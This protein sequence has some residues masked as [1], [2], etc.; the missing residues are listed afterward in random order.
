MPAA[1]TPAANRLLAA[2]DSAA[3][4]R[5]LPKLETVALSINDVLYEPGDT[6]SDVYFPLDTIVSLSYVLED[7]A[8]T[9][10]AVVG[11]EGM[12]GLAL[13]TGGETAPFRAVVQSDG[14]A[15]RMKGKFLK[16]E[17]DRFERLHTLLL[18][19]IQSLLTQM[20]QNAV[21]NRHHTVD[22]QLCRWLLLSLDRV[23]SKTL[24]MTQELIAT[25]LGV[26]REAVTTAARA[27]QR[28]GVIDYSRGHITVLDRARLEASSC[29]CYAVVR[30]ETDRL[31]PP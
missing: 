11:N 16:A 23:P 20:A 19:Y 14:E 6:V 21:C 31:L 25:N 2:L 9:D 18:R 24:H 27:L 13:V 3:T 30:D 10:I 1:R 26:R 29:E 7:G 5:V 4:A 17:F 28:R 15:L 12:T 8:A 22:Q